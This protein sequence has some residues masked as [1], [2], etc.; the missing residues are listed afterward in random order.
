LAIEAKS[1]SGRSRPALTSRDK[2]ISAL[3]HKNA[4][5]ASAGRGKVNSRK[6][7]THSKTPATRLF[8]GHVKT[9]E[10]SRKE[11]ASEFSSG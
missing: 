6:S 8:N 4:S 3:G 11:P 5:A 10:K 7:N 1:L 2:A 9:C